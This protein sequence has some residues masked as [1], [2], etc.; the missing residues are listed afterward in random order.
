MI[1]TGFNPFLT[2]KQPQPLGP[3]SFE[4]AL[5]LVQALN[6]QPGMRILEVGAGSGQIA[7]ALA[8]YWG[9]S[10]VTLEPWE[11]LN[12]IHLHANEESVGNQVLA[13]NAAAQALPFAES[14]FDAVLSIGS[15]FMIADERPR[16]LRELIRVAKRKAHIGIAEPMCR[17]NHAPEDITH[18]EIYKSYR[19][20]LQ[21][22]Q[23][24]STLFNQ[25]GLEITEASYF[26]N[27]YQMWVDN[28]IY[29]DGEKD[30]ILKDGGRWLSTG[31]VV[32]KKN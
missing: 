13:V 23:W 9:V 10:V 31:M 5:P 26:E 25:N 17:T 20:W 29:Y 30:I 4:M 6:L 15:F 2:I 27:G 14:S 16:A 28:L 18:F 22:V 3:G 12:A 8:K 11:D 24:N 7:A 21:T 19:K 1:D 32:G